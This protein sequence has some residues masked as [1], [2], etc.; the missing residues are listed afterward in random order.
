MKLEIRACGTFTAAEKAFVDGWASQVFAG[1][2][3]GLVWA[4]SDYRVLIWE[5][6]E[7]ACSVEILERLARVGEQAV[8]LGGIS[9]VATWPAYRR[10][11]LAR[12]AMQAAMDFL[13]FELKVEQGLLLCRPHL[14]HFY[15][16]L[17][18]QAV[19]GSLAFDQP[20]GKGSF[21]DGVMVWPCQGR[22]WPAGPIDLCGLPW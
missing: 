20:G 8:R 3:Q 17:G 16:S 21:S 15:Q 12:R 19:P 1:Q 22:P 9:G 18:W 11:G 7:L 13:R 14:A 10:R 4:S 6:D 2:D 5:G